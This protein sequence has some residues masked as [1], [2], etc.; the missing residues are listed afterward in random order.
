MLQTFLATLTPM[1]TLF[2]CIAVGFV[3]AKTKILPD[4]ASKTMAKMETWIFCPALSFMTMVRFCTVDTIS[5]HATNIVMASISVAVAMVIAIPLSKLFVKV[6]SPERGVYAYALA[7]ANSGYVG[8]PIVLALFGEEG[9]AYYKLF[10]LPLSIV[11]YT[12]GIS[13]LTPKT[14]E[15][16]STFKRLCNAPTVA[17]LIGI[18]VGLSGLG[19]YLPGF[20]TS[21]LDTLKACMGPVAMLL[22]GVTIAKYD[23]LGMI[24]KKKVYLAT[25]LRLTAIP[26]VLIAVLFG[27]KTLAGALFGLS[28]GNDVLFLCFFATAAPLGLNTVVFPE[29]YGGNPETGA[30]MAMISHTLCVVSIPLMYALMVALFG[31]PFAA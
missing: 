18:A 25:L 10:C 16:G 11:I 22:A 24:K 26:A 29:A 6:D 8:D 13:V 12:W 4:T 17:M 14:E 19:G 3:S 21:A 2:L 31:T 23:L 20:V 1:L 27:A 28:I 5:T 9:L 30:S 7:F 15:K